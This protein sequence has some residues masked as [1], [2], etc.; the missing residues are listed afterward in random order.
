LQAAGVQDIVSKSLGTTNPNNVV[1]ATIEALSQ[2]R[3][4]KPRAEPAE[5]L[6]VS[7]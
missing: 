4:R 2:L 7:A 5:P 3:E 6:A 1:R